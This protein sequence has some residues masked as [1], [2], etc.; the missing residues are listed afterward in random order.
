MTVN[1][2]A[3][4]GNHFPKVSLDEF[5]AMDTK[6]NHSMETKTTDDMENYVSLQEMVS[7][8]REMVHSHFHPEK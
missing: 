6:V 3:Q 2:F 8:L 1:H 5:I 4:T 7:G